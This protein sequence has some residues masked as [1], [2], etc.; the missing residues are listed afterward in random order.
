MLKQDRLLGDSVISTRDLGEELAKISLDLAKRENATYAELRLVNTRSEDVSV[1]N[2]NPASEEASTIG[3]GIRVLYKDSGW[4]FADTDELE[5]DSIRGTTKKALSLARGASKL[6]I[7]VTRAPEPVHVDKWET[8]VK[9][10]PFRVPT[11]TKY[12][13][14]QDTT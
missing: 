13:L 9:K 5:H 3:V 8:P 10:D 1:V 14:L 11:E 2:E 6:G 12:E 7:K 4:G